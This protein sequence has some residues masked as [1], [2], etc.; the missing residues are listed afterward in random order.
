MSLRKTEDVVIYQDDSWYSSFP[1][2][3]TQDD[4]TVLCA[5]RRA[6]ERRKWGASGVT[7]AD[8]NSACVLV[9]SEDGGETWSKQP[10]TVWANPLAGNQDPCMFQL[11]DG[12]LLCSTFSWMLL[13]GEAPTAPG[14]INVAHLGW[15][16]VNLGASCL[17][18]TD[19]GRT[20]TAPDP[21]SVVEDPAVVSHLIEKHRPVVGKLAK[22]YEGECDLGLEELTAAGEVGLQRAAASFR[23]GKHFDFGTYASW[24]VRWAI[25]Y[26]LTHGGQPL[27]VAVPIE[28]PPGRPREVYPGLPNR[29]ACRG[30]MAQLPDGRVLWPL[31]GFRKGPMPSESCVYASDDGGETWRYLSLVAEDE[32][33]GFNETSL[34]L[35]PSGRLV[36]FLR[37]TGLEG[38]LVTA[39][40]S[41]GGQTWSPWR[42]SSIWGHPF[43]PCALKDGRVALIYGHRREP[44]GIRMKLLDPECSDLETAE[45]LVLRTDGG[46][47]DIGYPWVTPLSES[48]LLCAYYMNHDD[49]TR[50]IAGSIVEVT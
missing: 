48:K 8:P 27:R 7:H 10:L 33:I 9:R 15:K 41:D 30:K 45:E 46:N 18:S 24:W 49:G 5:F 28:P 25:T 4:G 26:A 43:T 17:R 36:A 3:V 1:S 29:G 37:T 19:G 16:M 22:E 40:S 42:Q 50:Y 6:P 14:I 34:H 13:H 44:F 32:A 23:E 20:W 31:Y 11:A 12:S 35:C 38:V 39:S 2:L 21:L 47:G